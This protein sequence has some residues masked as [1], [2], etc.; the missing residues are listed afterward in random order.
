MSETADSISL[1]ELFDSSGVLVVTHVDF[2][3]IAAKTTSNIQNTDS[4]VIFSFFIK[5]T[6][7]I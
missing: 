5:Y 6:H 7:I 3:I 4:I 2:V 1:P